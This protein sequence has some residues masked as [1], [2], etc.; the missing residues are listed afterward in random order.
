M[1]RIALGL[2]KLVKYI[3]ITPYYGSFTN[4]IRIY[5]EGSRI[6]KI[7]LKLVCSESNRML[8]TIKIINGLEHNLEVL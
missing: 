3:A 1:G 4:I 7:N 8:I 6:S 2:H 5:C